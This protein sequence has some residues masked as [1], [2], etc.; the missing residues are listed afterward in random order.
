ML[1]RTQGFVAN[2]CANNSMFI[3]R[4]SLHDVVIRS[5]PLFQRWRYG[6]GLGSQNTL[7]LNSC[8][9]TWKSALLRYV[10]AQHPHRAEH[11]RFKMVK[12][13]ACR[14]ANWLGIKNKIV[15]DVACTRCDREFEFRLTV[16]LFGKKLNRFWPHSSRRLFTRLKR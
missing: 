11:L 9:P 13:L 5:G 8:F 2:I 3:A 12:F 15:F 1:Q 4:E 6:D 10:L 16:I 14:R 7:L